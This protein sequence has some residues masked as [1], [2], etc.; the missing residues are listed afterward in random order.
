MAAPGG[1]AKSLG[2]KRPNGQDGY[3][4]LLHCTQVTK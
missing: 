1:A 2:R 3:A 4:L